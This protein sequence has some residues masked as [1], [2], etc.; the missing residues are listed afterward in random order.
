M[1]RSQSWLD[2]VVDGLCMALW[3]SGWIFSVLLPV[4]VLC[5]LLSDKVRN[6]APVSV[7]LIIAGVL[8]LVGWF[9]RWLARGLMQGKIVRTVLLALGFGGFGLMMLL[10][11]VVSGAQGDSARAGI[12]L[13][14]SL[15]YMFGG[16]SVFLALWKKA[17]SA[18]P[19]VAAAQEERHVA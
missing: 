2:L 19:Q 1:D 14:Q 5:A 11:G 8:P 4:V 12:L 15:V 16:V 7:F 10:L 9:I 18:A 17:V 13:V 3:S 6:L